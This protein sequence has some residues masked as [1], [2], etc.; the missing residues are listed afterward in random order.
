MR[1]AGFVTPL[2]LCYSRLPT[3]AWWVLTTQKTSR[4]PPMILR[5]PADCAEEFSTP[6]EKI[7]EKAPVFDMYPW[8]WPANG[9]FCGGKGRNWL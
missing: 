2:S 1:T 3:S 7:V 9:R 5:E 8:V 4:F 6:V